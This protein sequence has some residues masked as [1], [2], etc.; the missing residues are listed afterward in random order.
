MTGT[1]RN[2]EI[3]CCCDSYRHFLRRVRHSIFSTKSTRFNIHKFIC[4]VPFSKAKAV[5]AA[6][7]ISDVG[8]LSNSTWK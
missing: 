6:L 8:M 3:Y 5:T 2:R 4:K 1:V 7:F